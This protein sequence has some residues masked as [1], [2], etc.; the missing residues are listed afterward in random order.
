ML[1]ERSVKIRDEYCSRCIICSS[2]CPFEA[3]SFNRESGEVALDIE[4]CQVCG[5]CFSACPSSS[6]EIAY[7]KVALLSEHVEKMRKNN[8]VLMCR[9]AIIRPELRES[10]RKNGAL[11]DWAQLYVPCVSR[12]PPEFLL[13]VIEA[14]VKRILI[15]P[16]EDNKCRFKVGSNISVS[17][18]L[19]L[20]KLLSQIGLNSDALSFVRSSIKAY[21][22]KYRCIGCGNCAYTCPNSAIKIMPPGV[23]Q[24]DEASCSGCGACVAVCPSLAINLEGFENN[25]ILETIS[26]HRSFIS[27][28]KSRGYGPMIAVFYCQWA[29]FPTPDTHRSYVRENIAFFEIPCSSM[30]NPLYVLHAFSEGFDGVLILACKKGECKFERGNELAER[31]IIALKSLLRQVNLENRL[32]ICFASPKYLGEIDDQIKLFM[33]KIHL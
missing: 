19:L 18:F 5:I 26:K 13:K 14:G 11:D 20:Q 29:N 4:K 15:I 21:I 8:L 3:I 2:I 10:L 12:I 33:S 28:A 23:A 22:N 16:C 1:N 7:Y 6:I 27:E 32:E 31:H 25:L 24:L 9:G 30:I 17:R